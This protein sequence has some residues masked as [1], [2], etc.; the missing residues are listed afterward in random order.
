ML[1][2]KCY[3]KQCMEGKYK[4]VEQNFN[5]GLALIGLSGTGSKRFLWLRECFLTAMLY[6]NKVKELGLP[7]SLPSAIT[8]ELIFVLYPVF[9][10]DKIKDCGLDIT[11]L[12]RQ[13]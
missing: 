11:N 2:P 3:S 1:T 5:P 7:R 4:I 8:L 6:S 9:P 10:S 12:D 13:L